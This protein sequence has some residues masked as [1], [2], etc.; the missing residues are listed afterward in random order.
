MTSSAKIHT[1]GCASI[2]CGTS[3]ISEVKLKFELVLMAS[4]ILK[5]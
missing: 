3:I 1:S 2:C 5:S 4:E